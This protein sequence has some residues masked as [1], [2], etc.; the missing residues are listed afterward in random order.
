MQTAMFLSW[1]FV[2]LLIGLNVVLKVEL[3]FVV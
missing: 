2:F 1:D 3:L